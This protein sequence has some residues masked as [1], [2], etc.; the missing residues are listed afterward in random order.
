MSDASIRSGPTI[1]VVTKKSGP[2]AV[3]AVVAVVVLILIGITAFVIWRANRKTPENI[4]EAAQ[5][6]Q[7]DLDKAAVEKKANEAHLA[8]DS[9][10]ASHLRLAADCRQL[11]GQVEEFTRDYLAWHNSIADLLQN[12]AGMRIAAVDDLVQDYELLR[13]HQAPPPLDGARLAALAQEIE[14]RCSTASDVQGTIADPVR[15][16]VA[17]VAT[18]LSRV[19]AARESVSRA[20][21]AVSSLVDRA[22]GKQPGSAKLADALRLRQERQAADLRSRIKAEAERVAKNE[23]EQQTK[24]AAD[25]LERKAAQ[26]VEA[27]RAQVQH[28]HEVEELRLRQEKAANAQEL[29][30]MRVAADAEIDKLKADAATA[31]ANFDRQIVLA[32][33]EANHVREQMTAE[34]KRLKCDSP[35]VRDLLAPFLAQGYWQ[36]T[37]DMNQRIERRPISLSLLNSAEAMSPTAYGLAK[38]YE[39]A[40]TGEDRERPRWPAYDTGIMADHIK[41][42]WFREDPRVLEQARKAQALLVELGPALVEFKLLSK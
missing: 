4:Q 7:A 15:E 24:V 36:P 11:R 31:K 20:A 41:D 10:R 16:D 33:E 13:E 8:N 14:A 29:A 26:E 17:T 1:D 34:V 19:T 28:A 23:I 42:V 18:E 27:M 38:L 9:A 12:E 39:I 21:A 2:G 6:L 25:G 40:A 5:L 35:V 30:R 32:H 22:A 3:Y 37:D